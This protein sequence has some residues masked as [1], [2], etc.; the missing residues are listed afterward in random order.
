M[1]QLN[2]TKLEKF[3]VNYDMSG[4]GLTTLF[5]YQYFTVKEKSTR[6]NWDYTRL[7][8]YLGGYQLSVAPAVLEQYKNDPVVFNILQDITDAKEDLSVDNN[9]GRRYSGEKQYIRCRVPY[10]ILNQFKRLFISTIVY[11]LRGKEGIPKPESVVFEFD[12]EKRTVL[13]ND[14]ILYQPDDPYFLYARNAVSTL[15]VEAIGLKQFAEEGKE[16]KDFYDGRAMSGWKEREHLEEDRHSLGQAGI[17]MLY[18]AKRNLFYVGK[19][20]NLQERLRQHMATENDPI[21]GF[22]HYRYSLIS[23]E[24]YDIIYL[25]ENAAIHDAAWI[26]EMGKSRRYKLPL[27]ALA[28]KYGQDISACQMVNSADHQTRRG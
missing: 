3:V 13:L 20:I 7:D 11:D 21:R 15:S 14:L 19:S 26:L 2:F 18:D 16:V 17:Y 6:K 12:P 22:T 9:K 24:Y 23:P 25:V 10:Y 5:K 28:K 8:R 27:A 1:D 4:R